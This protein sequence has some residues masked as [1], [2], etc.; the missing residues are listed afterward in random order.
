M[1]SSEVLHGLVRRGRAGGDPTLAF[2]EWKAPGSQ[3][4]PGCGDERCMHAPGTPGCALDDEAG[5]R[6]ANPRVD[7]GFIAKERRAL[8]PLGFARERLGLEDPQDA[9]EKPIPPERWA[10]WADPSSR[11]ADGVVP[12]FAFDVAPDRSAAAVSVSGRRGDGRRHLGLVAHERGD[13]WLV[14]RV[15]EL[16]ERHR[17]AAIVL[18]GASPAA[19]MLPELLDRGLEVWSQAK[20]WGV[21]VVT[22]GGDM[23]AA[24]GGLQ[25]AVLDEECDRRHRGDLIVSAALESAVRRDIGDGG[26]GW[27]R[28]RTD[29]DITPIVALTLADWGWSRFGN[30]GGLVF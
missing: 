5:W 30:A 15:V 7:V 22:S 20:P 6:A 29:A 8:D 4:R 10:R 24:C 2:A 25:S 21:L 19:A 27:A 18:D 23:A 26:W 16:H 17:P 12:V 14:D 28:K 1:A 9:Q 3:D 13:Q 11:V